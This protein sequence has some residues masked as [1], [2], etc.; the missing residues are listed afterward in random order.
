MSQAK[1]IRC[2]PELSLNNNVVNPDFLKNRSLFFFQ[3]NNE[4][5]WNRC[6]ELSEMTHQL[7][8]VTVALSANAHR[9][10]ATREFVKEQPIYSEL[11]TLGYSWRNR[12]FVRNDKS[13]Q[14]LPLLGDMNR[15]V[16]LFNGALCKDSI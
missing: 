4:L 1:I 16:Q 6:T 5:F 14:L 9:G 11:I 12:E 15:S 7:C 2:L 13:Y 10:E 3:K 8:S